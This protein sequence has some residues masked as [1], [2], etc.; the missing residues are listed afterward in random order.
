MIRKLFTS[1]V[2]SSHVQVPL[3]L[4]EDFLGTPKIDLVIDFYLEKRSEPTAF[5]GIVLEAAFAEG[6][7]FC[8]KIGDQ[9][10][11]YIDCQI[12]THKVVTS[13]N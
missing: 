9:L 6:L 12:K 13:L 4:I 8:V 2:P 10:E 7:I 11:Y 1:R 3:A 5:E